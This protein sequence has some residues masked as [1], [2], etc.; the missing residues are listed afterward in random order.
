LLE[1]PKDYVKKT[2]IERVEN[3]LKLFIREKTETYQRYVDGKKISMHNFIEQDMADFFKN[4]IKQEII[5]INGK[6]Y[7]NP[8]LILREIEKN[9]K[10]LNYLTPTFVP[11]FFHGDSLLRNYLKISDRSIKIIDVRGKNLPHNTT[12][13]ICI[14]FELGK[15]LHSIEMD[16]VRSDNFSLR[17]DKIKNN[18]SVEF[19]YHVNNKNI[20]ELLQ[21]RE[22]MPTVFSKNKA[23]KI[24][25]QNEPH[26][27]K[28]SLLAEA[29]HFLSDAIN[30]LAQDQRG[31]HALAYFIIGTK[32]LNDLFHRFEGVT[33][34]SQKNRVR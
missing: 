27:L 12:S 34:P 3:R 18:I 9:K 8:L 13:Q 7:K 21:V 31:Y 30:R 16:I 15:I 25:L 22:Q 10:L 2:H 26:W 17:V 32:L 6:V 20:Y 5:R 4:L 23:L 19:T 29:C 33:F 14:P 11:E 24:F 28:Q 1:T